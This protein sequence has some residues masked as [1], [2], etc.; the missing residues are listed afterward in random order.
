MKKSKNHS[1]TIWNSTSEVFSVTGSTGAREPRKVIGQ[2]TQTENCVTDCPIV[3]VSK[4]ARCAS[5][6]V[7]L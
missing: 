4:H 7:M 6:D 2:V 5:K 3:H 1:T